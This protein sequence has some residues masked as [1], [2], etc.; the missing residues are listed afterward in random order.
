MAGK[1]GTKRPAE[2][3]LA[4]PEPKKPQPS[5]F[6]RLKNF[7]SPS[8]QGQAAQ[9][10]KDNLNPS[11]SPNPIP[12]PDPPV[13]SPPPLSR[14]EANQRVAKAVDDYFAD[15]QEKDAEAALRNPQRK[16]KWDIDI[17][18]TDVEYQTIR[19]EIHEKLEHS[20]VVDVLNEYFEE[21][22]ILLIQPMVRDSIVLKIQKQNGERYR[23][24]LA[25]GGAFHG[26]KDNMTTK[27][28]MLHFGLP[29]EAITYNNVLN[30][31]VRD[32]DD[33]EDTLEDFPSIQRINNSEKPLEFLDSYDERSYGYPMPRSEFGYFLS[34]KLQN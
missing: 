27:L 23:E 15:K 6:R 22:Q 34:R 4:T 8:S 31:G 29:V 9:A 5:A 33:E 7:L 11:Q 10:T 28:A 30:A 16:L 1:T 18:P 14:M 21:A 20:R 2:D 24:A 17:K 26:Q 19:A 25:P 3:E 13:A 12:I 32:E